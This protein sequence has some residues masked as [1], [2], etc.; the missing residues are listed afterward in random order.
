[1]IAASLGIRWEQFIAEFT[2]PRWPGVES[3]LILH[4]S[5]GC[6]FLTPGNSAVEHLCSIHSFKPQCCRD[7]QFDIGQ[8]E[9]QEGLKKIWN[10]TLDSNGQLAGSQ[11]DIDDFGEYSKSLG[12]TA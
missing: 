9:C 12:R 2:D 1:L 6:I 3:Y 4:N 7:W 8:P 11:A 5:D 10:L